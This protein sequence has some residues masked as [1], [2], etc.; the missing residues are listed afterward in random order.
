MV[1][2]RIEYFERDVD[3]LVRLRR[4]R[5]DG[6]VEMIFGLVGNAGDERQTAAWTL[7]RIV[8]SDDWVEGGITKG[9]NSRTLPPVPKFDRP[10]AFKV[11]GGVIA[12]AGDLTLERGLTIEGVYPE[13]V[14][15]GT[16]MQVVAA[17]PN[18]DVEPLIWLYEFKDG[19]R[20]PFVFRKAVHL[21]AKT[22]IRG[23]RPD[24]R[25]LLIPA[26]KTT[27]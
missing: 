1:L 7:A 20:H 8:R 11:P 14:P 23:V 21:P 19:C 3:F 4:L 2:P 26:R 24:A 12:V 6:D 18:G 9:N 16:S 22:V 15:D 25:V 13:H 10:A 5:P 27:K 17:L